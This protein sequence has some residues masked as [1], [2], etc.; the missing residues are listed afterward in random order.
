[1]L[2]MGQTVLETANPLGLK[3]VIQKVVAIVL[4]KRSKMQRG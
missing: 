1:M 4:R 2:A 3:F